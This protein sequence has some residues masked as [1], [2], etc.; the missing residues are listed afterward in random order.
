MNYE[1]KFKD[2]NTEV[3]LYNGK[4]GTILGKISN[5]NGKKGIKLNI[6]Y[7]SRNQFKILRVD[8]VTSSTCRGEDRRCNELQI[9][10]EVN[11]SNIGSFNIEN[12]ECD[13]NNSQVLAIKF[14]NTEINNDD[15][16]KIKC[17]IC[18]NTGQSPDVVVGNI[19]VGKN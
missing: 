4:D 1:L 9:K 15:H 8:F 7:N 2:T 12:G 13:F 6:T 17:K 3:V 16:L 11:T 18:Y 19:L 14:D 10:G 5:W